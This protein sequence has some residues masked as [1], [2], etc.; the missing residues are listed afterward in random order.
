M[1]EQVRDDG[2]TRAVF[3]LSEPFVLSEVEALSSTTAFDFAQAE[4]M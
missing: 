3:D 2:R 4:R 1:P